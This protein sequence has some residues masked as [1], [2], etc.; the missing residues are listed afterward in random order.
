MSSVPLYDIYKYITIFYVCQGHCVFCYMEYIFNMRWI[1]M[2]I[3]FI[4]NYWLPIRRVDYDYGEK[5]RKAYRAK[6]WF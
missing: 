6:K 1:I 4:G 5:T 3:Q 2:V